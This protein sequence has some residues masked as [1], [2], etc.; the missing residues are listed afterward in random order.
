MIGHSDTEA[1]ARVLVQYIACDKRV[2]SEIRA[3]FISAPSLSTI[4]EIREQHHRI[5]RRMKEGT[6]AKGDDALGWDWRGD[7]Y[8]DRMARASAGFVKA[9]ERERKIS[10]C[11]A[12]KRQILSEREFVNAAWVREIELARTAA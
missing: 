1:M 6:K 8:Q 10:P 4:R 11:R 7:A 2:Q 5:A 3:H 12:N 9:I